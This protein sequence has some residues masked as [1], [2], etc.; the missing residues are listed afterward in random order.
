MSESFFMSFCA[1]ILGII[2]KSLEDLASFTL[3]ITPEEHRT[4]N[5]KDFYYKLA[6]EQFIELFTQKKIP[7]LDLLKKLFI[8]KKRK[9]NAMMEK[10]KAIN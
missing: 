8:L 7:K 10:L 1:L 2:D 6:L 5:S 9:R 4:V 3:D